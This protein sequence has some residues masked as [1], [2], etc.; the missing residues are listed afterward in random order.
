MTTRPVRAQPPS[1][2]PPYDIT[3]R[4]GAPTR[5][6]S[7]GWRS[8]A[9]RLT[10]PRDMPLAVR[11]F[12]AVGSSVLAFAPILVTYIEQATLGSPGTY[13]LFMPFW[14][15]LIVLG[16][17]PR[18]HGREI[19]DSEF[20][21]IVAVVIGA[22]L[23][24][25]VSLAAPR[26]PA[27][28][29]FWHAE[30]IPLLIWVFA[31]SIVIFGIR[32]V[33][34]DYVVWL[35]LLACFPPNILLFAQMLGGTTLAVGAVTIIL[36]AIATGL[37]FRHSAV[38]IPAAL[39]YAGAGIAMVFALREHPAL[40]YTVPAAIL[41]AVVIVVRIRV[42]PHQATGS[43]PRHSIVTITAGWA[44]ALLVLA[45]AP[46]PLPLIAPSDLPLAQSNWVDEI[47][48]LPMM[49]VS[50]PITYS[51]GPRVLGD[52]GSVQRYRITARTTASHDSQIAFLDVFTSRDLGRFADYRRG[53]W[54]AAAPPAVW[55]AYQ[56]TTDAHITTLGEMRAATEAVRTPDDDSLWTARQWGWK[57]QV[58][59]RICFQGI[60]LLASLDTHR[61]DAVTAPQP[62]SY[63]SVVVAPITWLITDRSTPGDIGPAIAGPV[64]ESLTALA[65][66]L[67]RTGEGQR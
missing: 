50:N 35:F 4:V 54:Y 6:P 22:G 42:G 55:T 23:I 59:N 10:R 3:E 27:A 61:P 37:A 9:R 29:A 53:V 51:W 39:T 7:P 33:V 15:L 18:S 14:G 66:R 2:P 60:Y 58:D 48:D 63:R 31:A 41:T 57:V 34:R 19:N 56:A 24:T 36:G 65:W 43:L 11:Y 38:A 45:F 30:V 49:L 17:D 52:G 44:A 32:R 8:V 46:R 1:A 26:L 21:R 28:A 47:S 64:E 12:T 20:D 67:V 62:P 40:A 13:L 5:P 25:A 16:L